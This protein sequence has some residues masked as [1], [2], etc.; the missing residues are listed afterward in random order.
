MT[1]CR[2]HTTEEDSVEELSNVTF[3]A[4]LL[5]TLEQ[6]AASDH[7]DPPSTFDAKILDGAAVLLFV[8]TAGISTF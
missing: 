3:D 2:Q 1:T 5:A 7:L 4:D 8:P 6:T